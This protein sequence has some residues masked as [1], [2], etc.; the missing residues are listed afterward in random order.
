MRERRHSPKRRVGVSSPHVN[1]LLITFSLLVAV[2]LT[3]KAPVLPSSATAPLRAALST[4]ES[5]LDGRLSLDNAIVESSTVTVSF[6]GQGDNAQGITVVLGHPSQAPDGRV[7]GPFVILSQTG[8]DEAAIAAL[9]T[10]LSSLS[11]KAIWQARAEKDDA[12]AGSI[13]AND[14]PQ[15]KAM[16]RAERLLWQGH[17]A[18]SVGAKELAK[19]RFD[20][21]SGDPELPSGAMLD[22]A[23]GYRR[24]NALEATTKTLERWKLAT[25]NDITSPIAT[26]RY[27]ILSGREVSVLK[28]LQD[29]RVSHNACG[30]DALGRAMDAVGNRTEAY[31]L[32]DSA[33]RKTECP[34]VEATLLEWFVADGRLYEAEQLSAV[35]TEHDAGNT[36]IAAVRSML[37]L[38]LEKPDEVV[39]LLKPLVE[40]H[41]KSSIL[42]FY[43]MAQHALMTDESALEALGA[44]SDEAI[45]DGLLAMTV[46]VGYQER[47]NDEAA[48]RYLERAEAVF[49]EHRLTKLIRARLTFNRGDR[50][51]VATILESIDAM[52]APDVASP[53][54]AEV[55]ALRGELLRWTDP[56][57]AR[58]TLK[59]T[60]LLAARYPHGTTKLARRAKAQAA[61]LEAC[62]S[63]KANAPC[64]GPF[65]YPK[66]HPSNEAFDDSEESVGGFGNWLIVI[67]VLILFMMMVRQ[68]RMNHQRASRW[69]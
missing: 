67:G 37:L 6:V 23:E 16:R 34:E 63:N 52:D 59:R 48:N 18:I 38:G 1:H 25:I 20:T 65:L 8:E 54:D 11:D 33:A 41:P 14:V 60:V 31:L 9:I 19:K 26:A 46:A 32:L 3:G 68:S 28:V 22:L 17:Q 58:D 57:A 21:L 13:R 44:K 10:R 53:L 69:K 62:I 66:D 51:A 39:A 27:E 2:Q 49:G 55:E 61:A 47:G 40:R 35:L 29:A 42:P 64:P 36:R 30:F 43:I 15:T 45:E 56:P 5:P 12:D 50:L 7:A 24:I 4:D